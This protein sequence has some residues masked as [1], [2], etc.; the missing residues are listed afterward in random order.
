MVF[1]WRRTRRVV[2]VVAIVVVG[3]I[4]SVLRASMWIR[5]TT[6]FVSWAWRRTFD[7]LPLAVLADERIFDFEGHATER[8]RPCAPGS[9]VVMVMVSVIVGIV[10]II[11]VVE[12][13]V[14]IL[15]RVDV[16]F[17]VGFVLTRS[18]VRGA[19]AS[20]AREH[21][22]FHV[23]LPTTSD[24]F[25]TRMISSVFVIE[26][27]EPVKRVAVSRGTWQNLGLGLSS[28]LIFPP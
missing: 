13:E 25:A 18:S 27:V 22:C 24:V 23:Q 26:P 10:A 15:V 6:V 7:W 16:V 4:G 1:P 5:R 19:S 28:R 20:A 11:V 12:T 21:G 17:I 3:V 9:V 2:V 14:D 8:K